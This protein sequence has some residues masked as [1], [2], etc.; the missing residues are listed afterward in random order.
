MLDENTIKDL[1]II[2]EEVISDCYNG[3]EF[4]NDCLTSFDEAVKNIENEYADS[5]CHS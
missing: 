5:S 4:V 1:P 2:T 3:D